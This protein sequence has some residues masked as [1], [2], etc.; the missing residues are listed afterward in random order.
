MHVVTGAPQRSSL[1]HTH[2]ACAVHGQ[3]CVCGGGG[4]GGEVEE[5]VYEG[6][7]QIRGKALRCGWG[8]GQG[9]PGTSQA[10]RENVPV[11]GGL[12]DSSTGG[13][14]SSRV[15]DRL[16]CPFW[17][18]A[19]LILVGLDCLPSPWRVPLRLIALLLLACTNTCHHIQLKH[20]FA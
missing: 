2:K 18:G 12:L 9:S 16:K 1:K 15:P 14:P 17:E 11:P 20:D 19:D 5:V 7:G 6:G 13:V 4:R 3:V 8:V 10:G